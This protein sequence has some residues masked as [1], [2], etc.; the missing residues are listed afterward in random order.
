MIHIPLS[1]VP[2]QT[3]SITLAGQA[4]QIAVRQNGGNLYFDLL[5][6]G[7]PV[8]RTRICRNRQRLLLDAQ[9][10]EIVGDFTFLDSQGDT[11]PQYTGLDDRYALYYLEAA[12]FPS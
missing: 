5:V 10:H 11:D 9:Y 4:C 3:L 12:D 8:V 1:Q 7:S 6:G 2:S